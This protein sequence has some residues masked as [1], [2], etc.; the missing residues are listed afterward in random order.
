MKY[1][2]L[3]KSLLQTA[4]IRQTLVTMSAT[5]ANGL[6][7]M[8]FYVFL[9]RSIT[10]SE[11]GI[12]TI[13]VATVALFSTVLDFGTDKGVV[14]FISK[15]DYVAKTA[16]LFKF[17]MVVLVIAATSL[18][19]KLISS[20]LFGSSNQSVIIP[21]IGLCLSGYLF[22]NTSQ[23][24]LQAKEKFVWW[25]FSLAGSNFL[26]LLIFSLL[27]FVFN[28]SNIYSAAFSFALPPIILF[29]AS[30]LPLKL[31]YLKAKLSI[32]KLQELLTFNSWVA[33][34]SIISAL[35]S[36]LD[37]F[38]SVRYLN[39]A[40]VGIYGLAGQAVQFLP[41]AVMAL[42]VVTAPK[43][44]NFGSETA[45]RQYVSKSILLTAGMAFASALVI[46][47]VALI[48]FS[49]SGHSYMSGFGTFLILLLSQLVFL[50]MT[51]IRD[52]L[53]YYYSR[54][55]LFFWTA[56]AQ[57]LVV[58]IFS[59]ILIPRYGIAGS[60][61]ANLSGQLIISVICSLSYAKSK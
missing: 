61:I 51:P 6:L 55:D 1:L 50:F 18:F 44:A 2:N 48:I 58:T 28:K 45:N 39:L 23:S 24:L 12:F 37:T 20:L 38:I 30:F 11:Y 53:M 60:A 54:P 13:L 27:V 26:R 40:D 42:G 43:F 7:A 3:V 41:Q 16:L 52:S 32:N 57:I 49:A 35:A 29:I 47:P 15:G 25:S 14:K 34:F 5:A 4:T 8:V 56:I 36:R 22:F 10:P 19:S 46:I 59:V 21:W 33:G 31:N 9:A 17:V